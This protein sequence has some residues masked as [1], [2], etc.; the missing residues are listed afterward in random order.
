MKNLKSK[1]IRS[2]T[3]LCESSARLLLIEEQLK[4]LSAAL[5]AGI[6]TLTHCGNI[7]PETANMWQAGEHLNTVA[8]CERNLQGPQE[9]IQH[10]SPDTMARSAIAMYY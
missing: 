7:I 10:H 1:D 9:I 3:S 2:Q 5:L 6:Y 8:L 4:L